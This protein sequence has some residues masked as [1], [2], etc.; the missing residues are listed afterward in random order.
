MINKMN[1]SLVFWFFQAVTELQSYWSYD[2]QLWKWSDYRKKRIHTIE[3]VP[4]TIL[5]SSHSL[6][7]RGKDCNQFLGPFQNLFLH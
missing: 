4:V 7:T 2:F 6:L 1:Y 3:K 5:I